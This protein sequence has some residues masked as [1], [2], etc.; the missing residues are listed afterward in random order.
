MRVMWMDG[1][2]AT[3]DVCRPPSWPERWSV[4]MLAAGL[5]RKLVDEYGAV[6]MSGQRRRGRKFRVGR[7]RKVAGDRGEELRA[8]DRWRHCFVARMRGQHV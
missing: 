8:D 2:G 5:R 3:D 1:L 7:M 4:R 6:S